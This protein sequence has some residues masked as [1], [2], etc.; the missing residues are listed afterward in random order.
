MNTIEITAEIPC[1]PSANRLWRRSG[2]IMHRSSEYNA[3]TLSAGRE[4]KSLVGPKRIAGLYAL[5]VRIGR[6]HASRDLGNNEKAISDL[7]QH[8]GVVDDDKHCQDIRLRW[9]AAVPKGRAVVS[10]ISQPAAASE[11][12]GRGRGS[13]R[14]PSPRTQ[15]PVRPGSGG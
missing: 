5:D 3:W 8:C 2:H 15:S 14:A 1:P 13:Q 10:I 7:L 9:D 11:A 4:L 6:P 12:R